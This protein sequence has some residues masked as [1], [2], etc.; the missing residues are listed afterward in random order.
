MDRVTVYSDQPAPREI[1]MKIIVLVLLAAIVIALFAGCWSYY[2][3]FRTK[4][5]G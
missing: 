3:S 5:A 2:W 1:L 4:W